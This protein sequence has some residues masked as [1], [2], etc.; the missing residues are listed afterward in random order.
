MPSPGESRPLPKVGDRD[1]RV[2]TARR[3]RIQSSQSVPDRKSVRCRV[4]IPVCREPACVHSE[5]QVPFCSIQHYVRTA[6]DSQPAY[7]AA[8]IKGSQTAS[9]GGSRP[10]WPR[11][12]M[13]IDRPNTIPRLAVQVAIFATC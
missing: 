5:M 4:E 11:N 12:W 9:S 6:P 2:R 3:K 13:P 1:G 7:A 8:P 10:P